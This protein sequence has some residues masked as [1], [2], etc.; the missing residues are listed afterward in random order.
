MVSFLHN[1]IGRVYTV[2]APEGLFFMMKESTVQMLKN[3][4]LT[5]S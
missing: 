4:T 1:Y 3:L 2:C 5:A